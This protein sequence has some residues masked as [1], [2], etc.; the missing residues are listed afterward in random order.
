M[1][2]TVSVETYTPMTAIQAEAWEL[3]SLGYT[4]QLTAT[5]EANNLLIAYD[6]RTI[7]LVQ[8]V[9]D[10]DTLINTMEL[11]KNVLELLKKAIAFQNSV[12]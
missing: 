3:L 10:D 8:D 11:D 12:C 7:F 2:T 6:N 1:T 4:C 5:S 9:Q